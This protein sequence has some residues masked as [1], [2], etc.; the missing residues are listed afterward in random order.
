LSAQDLPAPLAQAHALG[1]SLIAHAENKPL[2]T[3]GLA[4]EPGAPAM[5]P[6]DRAMLRFTFANTGTEVV[7][8]LLQPQ[9]FVA[10]AKTD[11]EWQTCWKQ[12]ESDHIGLLG[13]TGNL[14]DGFILPATLSPGAT[15]TVVFLQALQRQVP[16]PLSVRGQVEGTISLLRRDEAPPRFPRDQFRLVSAPVTLTVRDESSSP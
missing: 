16:G 5:G 10:Q 14:V 4:C 7:T 6:G 1:Q 15:A 13:P 11:D 12:G 3:V 8:F 9:T 2:A